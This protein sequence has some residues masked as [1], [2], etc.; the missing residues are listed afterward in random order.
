MKLRP[1]SEEQQRI[2]LAAA[3]GRLS[4][5]TP[6]FRYKIEDEAPPDRKEREKLQKRGL[7]SRP[8]PSNPEILTAK[9]REA[10]AYAPVEEDGLAPEVLTLEQ[11][12]EVG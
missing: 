3:E 9:G 4:F 6:S 12:G 11:Q 5:E 10:L 1:I 8:G 7:L 2:L